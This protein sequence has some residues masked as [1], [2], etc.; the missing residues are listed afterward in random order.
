MNWHRTLDLVH[1]WKA[2]EAK[3]ITPQQLAKT[4]AEKLKNLA[5]SLEG[6]NAEECSLLAEEL[7]SAEEDPKFD[8]DDFDDVMERIYDLGDTEIRRGTKLFWVKR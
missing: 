7:D 8:F 2:A 1:C 6:D 5:K 4:V 3:E